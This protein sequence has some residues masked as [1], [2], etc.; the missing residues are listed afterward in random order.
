MRRQPLLERIPLRLRDAGGNV[1]SLVSIDEDETLS[2]G[3]S[4]S[5][6]TRERVDPENVEADPDFKAS[7]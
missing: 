5:S 3:G 7:V 6:R 4:S 1:N 2:G